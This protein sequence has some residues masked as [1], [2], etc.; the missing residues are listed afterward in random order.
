MRKFRLGAAAAI[1][2]A[3]TL[4][5]S[6][7]AQAAYPDCGIAL[8][9]NNS[10]VVGGESFSFK[11][12]SGGIDCDWTVT[13]AGKTKT[14]SGTSISGSFSTKEVSK[15][16]TT[17]ITA[18]CEHEVADALSRSTTSADVT[19]AFY[20]TG[21][22]ETIQAATRTCPVSAHVTLLPTGTAPAHEEDDGVLPNT[23]GA[24]FW[25]LVLGGA[26]VVG[27][28]GITFASR[29]RHDSR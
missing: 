18:S 9:L 29:R 26:L 23:G 21:S 28:A 15:K 17:T 14:G 11:A 2:C 3:V 22:S 27:G 8:S 6:G 16:T 25:I 5:I 4:L 10:T 7:A 12:D 24:N 13:Y 19:P 20:S 1:A